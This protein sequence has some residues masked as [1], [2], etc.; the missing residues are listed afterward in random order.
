M[1]RPRRRCATALLVAL[2]GGACLAEAGD[3]SRNQAFTVRGHALTLHLYGTRGGPTAVVSSGDGG[4]VHLAPAVAQFLAGQGWFVAGFDSKAYLSSFTSGGRTLSVSDVPGDYAALAEH[5][6]QGAPG[7]PLLMGVSEGA[8]LSVLAATAP[9][10]QRR[11][12]GV[13]AIGLPEVT[14]PHLSHVA[15]AGNVPGVPFGTKTNTL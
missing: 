8:G 6:A 10:V 7:P 5:A 13:V 2:V 4:W 3:G 11:I 14:T 9:E 1:T 12:A 15:P